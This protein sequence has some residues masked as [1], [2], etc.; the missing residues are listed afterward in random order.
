MVVVVVVVSLPSCHFSRVKQRRRRLVQ[1]ATISGDVYIHPS[2]K[3]HPTAKIGPNISISVNARIGAGVTC[4]PRQLGA[5]MVVDFA[6]ADVAVVVRLNSLLR[7][8]AKNGN[9]TSFR[10][11]VNERDLKGESALSLAVKFG[12]VDSVQV[13]IESG[14]TIDNKNDRFLHE[15]AASGQVDLMEILCL[16]YVDIDLNS[17]NSQNQTAL[18]VAT[19]HGHVEALQFLLSIGSD[20]D[21]TDSNGWTPLHFIRRCPYDARRGGGG[22]TVVVVVVMSTVVT[23]SL[24]GAVGV[25]VLW[26]SK[27]GC[28]YCWC[29]SGGGGETLVMVRCC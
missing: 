28:G 9:S 17:V 25:V 1:N 24:V 27:M 2:A 23:A 6:V 3:V 19:I 21:I 8:D 4:V 12:N 7:F 5:V 15:T 10:P 14:S 29:C 11:D 22:V 20:P 13:L 16:G 18:H 26:S